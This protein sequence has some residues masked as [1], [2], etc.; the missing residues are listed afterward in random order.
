MMVAD[1]SSMD[2]SRLISITLSIIHFD[3][4]NS[5]ENTDADITRTVSKTFI[6]ERRSHT[7]L[8]QLNKNHSLV[9]CTIK[10]RSVCFQSIIDALFCITINTA[11]ITHRFALHI[12][13]R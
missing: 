3:T 12:I 10:P 7:V 2:K 6:H 13:R 5:L 8:F 9:I 1:P 4:L 11:K